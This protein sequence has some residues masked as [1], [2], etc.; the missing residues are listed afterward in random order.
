MLPCLAFDSSRLTIYKYLG[1]STQNGNPITWTAAGMTMSAS[2]SG[3]RVSEPRTVGKPSILV[4]RLPMHIASAF[5]VP[6]R[7]LVLIGAISDR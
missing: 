3:H 7:P 5:T 6:I 2:K 1:L 4:T